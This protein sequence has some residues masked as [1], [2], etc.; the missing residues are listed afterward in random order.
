M[1]T[2]NL[3]KTLDELRALRKETEWVE[4]KQA[5]TSFDFDRLGKYFS[6]LSNEANLKDRE[7]GW[8]VFGI[9]DEDRKIIGTQYRLNKAKLDR[10]KLEVANGTTNRMTFMEIHELLLSEGRVIM[11]Q[12]PAA[13]R[14]IPTAWKGHYYGREGESIN[15]L[16]LQEI[17]HMRS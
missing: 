10:L 3:K 1:N 16:S 17:E 14:G 13:T 4:F 2:R 7:Y 9:T 11:F 5:R 8:L 12:V 6:A 15:A